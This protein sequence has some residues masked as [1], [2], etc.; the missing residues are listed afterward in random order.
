[1]SYTDTGRNVCQASEF[2]WGKV[3]NGHSRHFLLFCISYGILLFVFAQLLWCTAVVLW[4]TT[5]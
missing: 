5:I 2:L 3:E 1:M 4:Y